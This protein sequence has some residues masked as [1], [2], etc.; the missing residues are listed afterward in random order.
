MLKKCFKSVVTGLVL[1]ALGMVLSCSDNVGLGESVDTESPSIEI[2]YPPA[3]AIIRGSFVFAGSWKD[4]KGVKTVTAIITNTATKQTYPANT[5]TVITKSKVNPENAWYVTV[6]N[7]SED[8]ADYVNNWQLPDGKYELGVYATD[9]AGHKS[10]I[11]TR[12]FEIDNTAPVTVLTSPGSTST[13]TAYGST[14]SVEGTIADEHAV[15]SLAVTIYDENGNVLDSTADEPYTETS[16]QTAGGTS[17]SLLKFSE[18]PVTD[19]QKRYSNIYGE[20]RE[21]GTKKYSCAIYVRDNARIYGEEE[22]KAYK[23]SGDATSATTGNETSVFYLNASV[24]ETLLSSVK[25]Y[26]LSVTDLMTIIN[27]TYVPSDDT[28]ARAAGNNIVKGTLTAEELK[29]VQSLLFG[30]KSVAVDTSEEHL[31]FSLDPAVNPI[32]TVSGFSLEDSPSGTKNQTV[33]FIVSPGLDGT[34]F[35]PNT[36]SVYLLNCGSYNA[37]TGFDSS[38]YNEFLA[39][40]AAY[41]EAHKDTTSFITSYADKYTDAD[42]LSSLTATFKLPEIVAD[43]YYI[44]GLSG[45]D[46]DDNELVSDGTFGFIGALS[47]TPPV[48]GFEKPANQ[49]ILGST[50]DLVF[51]GE[52][53]TTEVKLDKL[54]LTIDVTD[55]ESGASVGSFKVSNVASDAGKIVSWDTGVE[56]D[57]DAKFKYAWTFALKD[58]PEYNSY[59]AEAGDGKIY[60]YTVTAEARDSSG[61]E[62]TANRTVTVDTLPPEV[63]ITSVIPSVSGYTD[64]NHSDDSVVYV[65][66]IITI[67]GSVNEMNHRATNYTVYVGDRPVEDLTDCEISTYSNF[68][69]VIDTTKL[70][71][72]KDSSGNPIYVDDVPLTV[73]VT[74]EDR[75]N[76][77]LNA[78]EN[79]LPAGKGKGN[80]GSY[81]TTQLNG[82]KPFHIL[83]ETD[84]PVIK[85]INA[86]KDIQGQADIVTA[87]QD[88]SRMNKNIFAPGDKLQVTVSDD[89]GI[90]GVTVSY[91][92]AES[93]DS[94]LSLVSSYTASNNSLVSALPANYG[95]YE[96]LVTAVDSVEGRPAE[97][98]G[99][100]TSTI[101]F[102]VAMDDGAPTFSNMQP[103]S[104]GYYADKIAVS[105]SLID[106]S[107]EVTL[108]L[109]SD[110]SQGTSE[111]T[112]KDGVSATL[113][114]TESATGADF[115]DSIKV[116]DDSQTYAIVYEATDLYGQSK[117]YSIRYIV[118]KENPTV[119][120]GS[121]TVGD[122]VEGDW[123]NN[124][125]PMVKIAVKDN[126]GGSGIA[127]VKAYVLKPS[128][129]A[130]FD[131]S[132]TQLASTDFT[133]GEKDADDSTF[134]TYSAIVTLPQGESIVKIVVEDQAHN[135][136]IA[137]SF[138]VKVDTLKPVITEPTLASD[139]SLINAVKKASLTSGLT[140]TPTL[141]DEGSGL[142]AAWLDTTNDESKATSFAASSKVTIDPAVTSAEGWKPALNVSQSAL[143]DGNH[144]YYVWAEDGAGRK[145]VSNPV[146]FTVDTKVPSVTVNALRSGNTY[147][148][149][150]VTSITE[151]NPRQASYTIAGTWTDKAG[152]FSGSGTSRLF[153]SIDSGAN[154]TEITGIDTAAGVTLSWSKE[155]TVREGL[156]RTIWFKAEDVAGNTLANADIPAELKID[157][158]NFDFSAPDISL[159]AE[160]ASLA[161]QTK[162]NAVINGSIE[163]KLSLSQENIS[164]VIAR[165][166]TAQDSA[167]LTSAGISPVISQESAGKAYAFVLTIPAKADHTNDGNWTVTVNANDDAGRAAEQKIIAVLIDTTAPVITS[168]PVLKINNDTHTFDGISYLNTQYGM[169]YA[170]EANDGSGSG[171]QKIEYT[172]VAGDGYA[173]WDAAS[174]QPLAFDWI[175][176]GD[177]GT[178]TVKALAEKDEGLY[179]FF[180]RITD[181]VGNVSYSEPL[182]LYSD[183]SDP[184][185]KETDGI[186][187]YINLSSSK[188]FTLSGTVTDAQNNLYR[189]TSQGIKTNENDPATAEVV[190]DQAAGTW[191]ITQ[192]V[193]TSDSDT[194]SHSFTYTINASDKAGNTAQPVQKTVYIDRQAPVITIE[195]LNGEAYTAGR[196]IN[197]ANCRITGK[198]EDDISGVATM[199]GY[200]KDKDG[201]EVPGSRTSIVVGSGSGEKE[202]NVTFVISG[203]GEYTPVFDASDNAGNQSQSVSGEV[204]AADFNPPLVELKIS[205]GTLVEKDTSS[206]P[207]TITALENNKNYGDNTDGTVNADKLWSNGKTYYT[208]EAF[209]IGGSVTDAFGFDASDIVFTVG[210]DSASIGITGTDLLNANWSYSQT[211]SEGLYSYNLSVK[212]KAGNA[213]ATKTFTVQVDMTG[214]TVTIARPVSGN[215]E[216][217]NAVTLSGTLVDAG[218]GV[219]EVS[220]SITNGIVTKEGTATIDGNTWSA[221]VEGLPLGRLTLTVNAKDYLDNTA[222]PVT[223]SFYRD[224]VKPVLT[225]SAISTTGKTDSADAAKVWFDKSLI[226]FTAAAKDDET[227]L[228]NILYSVNGGSQISMTTPDANGSASASNVVLNEGENTISIVA[229]DIVG[230]TSE[231]GSFS[232]LKA[233]VDTTKPAFSDITL[234]GASNAADFISNTPVTYSGSVTEDNL[235]SLT[236]S[237][238]LNG[239]DTTLPFADP[240]VA[241]NF[242][243]TLP[244]TAGDG[245]WVFTVTVTDKAGNT[246]STTTPAVLL[247]TQAPAFINTDAAPL[248]FGGKS[249]AG[250]D[251]TATEEALVA[252]ETVQAVKHGVWLKDT[253]L[254]FIGYYTESGSGID[255]VKCKIVGSDGN[256]KN[257]LSVTPVRSKSTGDT[258]SEACRFNV[259]DVSGIANG[260]IISFYA[261]DNAKNTSAQTA[262]YKI[263]ID[264]VDPAVAPEVLVSVDD[265]TP[266]AVTDTILS[267][268]TKSLVIYAQAT[269]SAS[270]IDNT[271]ISL[272]TGGTVQYLSG[273]AS[274]AE[275]ADF[276]IAL[277]KE[278]LESFGKT[279]YLNVTVKDLAG[280]TYTST[281]ATVQIDKEAPTVTIDQPSVASTINKTITLSGS[282]KD[283][284]KFDYAVL[285]YSINDGVTW[286]KFSGN[287]KVSLTDEE[288]TQE[289]DTTSYNNTANASTLMV[290]LTG[291]DAAGNSADVTK[292]Y[293]INQDDDRPIVKI[294]NLDNIGSGSAKYVLKYATNAQLTG[295]VIDDDKSSDEDVVTVLKI[296][297]VTVDDNANSSTFEGWET[298]WTV[299][300]TDGVTTAS[301]AAYGTTTLSG[302]EW[303]FTPASANQKDGAYKLYFYVQDKRSSEFDSRVTDDDKLSENDVP[304]LRRP[305]WQ[306][307]TGDKKDT[308]NG[309]SYS[310]DGTSPEVV[311]SKVQAGKDAGEASAAELINVDSSIVLGGPK[312]RYAIFTIPARDANGVTAISMTVTGKDRSDSSKDKELS[313]S[314]ETADST[315]ENG[316]FTSSSSLSTNAV[317]KT[318]PVDFGLFAT[319]TVKLVII[320]TDGSGLAGRQTYDFKI[321]Q[322]G[323]NL[324]VKSPSKTEEKTGDITVQGSALDRGDAG[325]ESVEY[326]VPT[327]A[328]KAMT[329]DQL[330]DE[331]GWDGNLAEDTTPESWE[332]DFNGGTSEHDNP[333]FI[334]F[335][336]TTKYASVLE[337]GIYTIPLYIKAT[338]ILGNSTIERWEIKH[339]PDG[340]KPKI[341]FTYPT[342][343]DYDK[344]SAGESLSYV[345]LGGTIRVAGSAI[346]PS[347]TTT[348]DK[349][350]Y[351]IADENGGFSSTD[352]A[353]ASKAITEGGYG[354]TVV[355]VYDVLNVAEDTVFTDEELRE[356]G[357]ASNEAAKAW[358]G[359]AAYGTASWNIVLNANGELNAGED[360]EDA[361]KI[362]LRACGLNAK[363]KFGVWSGTVAIH[364]DD[365]APIISSVI[366]KYDEAITAANASTAVPS[367]SQDYAT[368]MFL[369][370]QWYLVL[371]VV[372][373][374]G[375]DKMPVLLGKTA[376]DESTY[377]KIETSVD[378][379]K[380]GVTTTKTGYIAFVPISQE[381]ESLTY[382]VTAVD[383][384]ATTHTATQSFSFKIDNT[385]PSLDNLTGNKASLTESPAPAIQNDSYVYKLAGESNDTGSGV[386]RVVFY[387]MRKAG[388]TKE[389]LT[390]GE[391]I[392]DPLIDISGSDYAPA[393]VA[394]PGSFDSV[395]DGGIDRLE[396]T[397]D[398]KTYYLYAYK[399]AGN[400]TAGT[401]TAKEKTLDA[402]VR[403]GGLIYIDG[404]YRKITAKTATTATFEPA[405]TEAKD[406][407]TAWFPIAQV[408]DTQI[409]EKTSDTAAHPFVFE[410]NKDDGDLMPESFNKIS[411][412]WY[413]DASIHSDNLPDGPISLVILAFD[414]AG[415]VNGTTINTK[416]TNN[417]P[418]L[419]KLFLATDLNSND[420]F[421]NEEFEVYNIVG[422]TGQEQAAYELDFES[423]GQEYGSGIF[424]AKNKLAVVPELVG[425]NG[426]ITLVAKKDADSKA[427]VTS[428]AG[429]SVSAIASATAADTSAMSLTKI[430]SPAYE[431][432]ADIFEAAK[433]GNNFYAYVLTNAQLTG[434]DSPTESDDGTNKPFSFTFWDSTEE[435][436]SGTDS[437]NSVLWV[438]NFTF[439][440]VDGIAPT[441]VVNPFYWKTLN[442]NSIYESDK[443]NAD[444][445]YAVSST[446]DL[447]GHIELEADW[448]TTKTYTDNEAADENEKNNQYDGDPKVSGK[449]T[450]T[451]TAYDE[452]AL[453]SL[454]FSFGKEGNAL[455]TNE[456]LTEYDTAT[457]KWSNTAAWKTANPDSVKTMAANGYEVT[458]VEDA[459]NEYGVYE[460]SVYFGQSGHKIYWTLSID[461]E[462]I[463]GIA[464]TDMVLTVL[465]TDLA[466]KTTSTDVTAPDVSADYIPASTAGS[467]TVT[468]GTTNVPSYQ[469]DIVPYVTKVSTALRS[470]LKSSIKDTYSRTA[471]GH[472]IARSTENITIEGFNLGS[473]TVKPKYGTTELSYTD[474]LVTLPASSLS[475]SGA[476]SLTVGDVETLN[477]MNN[478]NA[479]GAYANVITENSLYAEKKKYAYNRTP[480][481]TSNNLLT[482]DLVVDVWEFN[483]EAA[484]PESGELREPV[485]RINPVSG[486]VGLA[487]VSGPAHFA[488]ANGDPNNLD[489][490]SYKTWQR[491]YATYNNVSFTYDAL[492]YSHA[493]GTGLDTNPSSVH[494]GKFTY[495]YSKWGPSGTDNQNG[496]YNGNNAMRLEGIGI[497]NKT[498]TDPTSE[499]E[500]QLL[501]NG[502][503]PSDHSLS[504]TRFNSPSIATTVHGSGTSVTT[505]VYLA[506]FDSIQRQIR[507]RYNS[508]LTGS[509]GKKAA[510]DDFRDNEGIGYNTDGGTYKESYTSRFSLIAGVDYQQGEVTTKDG[511]TCLT[512]YDT[513]YKAGKYVSI[514]AIAGTASAN[515]VVVAV[516]YDG[517][518]CWY[519]YNTAPTSGK[520]NGAAGGWAGHKKI[521]SEGGE[522]CA[523]KV[524]PNNGI[525]IAAYVDGGL[526]YAYLSDYTK[527]ADYSESNDSV[528][529]DSFTVVGE[530]ITIDAGQ[531]PVKVGENTTYVVVPYISYFNGTSRLPSVAK[532]V[533]PENGVM[534]YKAQGTGTSDGNDIF[535][536]N[537][538]VSL[539]PSPK[540]LTVMYYDKI[541]IGLW[542]LNK[543]VDAAT[544]KG[545]IVNSNDSDFSGTV[546]NKTSA[547]N[548]AGKSEGHIYG[549]GTANPIL[550][551]AIDSDI[552]TCFETAQM[553]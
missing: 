209:T 319:E 278:Q 43:N 533:V 498:Y 364:V 299:S 51:G 312:K 38:K 256:T 210:S 196:K 152:T 549:N 31:R 443:I 310:V 289:I 50:A 279:N 462:K 212:D 269:D 488:M 439:D 239:A 155:I 259:E 323:P 88:S 390:N 525:H 456:T 366:R 147:T 329:D 52:V 206:S 478:N 363:K 217:E 449:I 389:T 335:D 46:L 74:S 381:S 202:W 240:A 317:W 486:K 168:Q 39:D 128:E 281:V 153:Y 62:N 441:V 404:L 453:K 314:T 484:I 16:I 182:K 201:N 536:G 476:V 186:D 20:S 18:R 493:T 552:G 29:E 429:T 116:P 192:S 346:I 518:D 96:I 230:N 195:N 28:T 378:E 184:V 158:L 374:S 3:S 70:W 177:D 130:G 454:A 491:N 403:T 143:N 526:R 89:D 336:D 175:R 344:D 131:R 295:T 432:T 214:P 162:E 435:T 393:K 546:K 166:G 119:K 274:G 138:T 451:G 529:V 384:D 40:P 211:A 477:N 213:A 203:D 139:E 247:D 21:G 174:S 287:G 8:N 551:Y 502:F 345:T 313:F 172:A 80:T 98:A 125:S 361:N 318:P 537:W 109:K 133:P 483:S 308:V 379:V 458:I 190:W 505:A 188:T 457:G 99:N 105:G 270:G 387:Y 399:V 34:Q 69:I 91:R 524:D 237:A 157:N 207:A 547:N 431:V 24:Y 170:V 383:K 55:V 93:S 218:I 407:I 309:L 297:N 77:E 331:T 49:A 301:H 242:S 126:D 327:A 9:H 142:V 428:A 6:N 234:T 290:K 548:T 394:M 370:G 469:M 511:K 517:T 522:H 111:T 95:V 296:A 351:Q 236:V 303:T 509:A 253:T 30:D 553:K 444:E 416:V 292:S 141:V 250:I 376:V 489:Y 471:L 440:L 229:K 413:W 108:R 531:V 481:Q 238:K 402:H 159:S 280:R 144:V 395:A 194:T 347:G 224:N 243:F 260:D 191:T 146:T 84:K 86:D 181:A 506:Y 446:G 225:A 438:K 65:N 503:V 245:S 85:P 368:D 60:M 304:Q 388:K 273:S 13:Y 461:T 173:S 550:G 7:Y 134:T 121:L 233:W 110:S 83:Q 452:H 302:N 515:D 79:L 367:A 132:N 10:G 325:T 355:S 535:T 320:P 377:V 426:A 241:N 513:G 538:E 263:N 283:K 371:T 357:F 275:T 251:V 169:D 149:N 5:V 465:A 380:N 72:E 205:A 338:D 436:T 123:F 136:T 165:D 12:T 520:D 32:Y 291:Y 67:T 48:I 68:K 487:F 348:V 514:D 373:E 112:F 27:G 463:T 427:P 460:D 97:N 508:N 543:T 59:K 35:R 420:K 200:L 282:A 208:K 44:I 482:D 189:V 90:S 521:F 231:A 352:A 333:S 171:I 539:V 350:F 268:T 254:T 305:Y 223:C 532:L 198:I 163:D 468:D 519:A 266:V 176:A 401:F 470:K 321:D 185:V 36:F 129:V 75:A 322:T 118:D 14:F 328:Q 330:A 160:T 179:T 332:F 78:N 316:S 294:T 415:N 421:E 221:N 349:V 82:G 459:G 545:V 372:D 412:T 244:A 369:R 300:T 480:N 23:A 64:A 500:V 353:K 56:K 497:P 228:A 386:E 204:F 544:V 178:A 22:Y 342:E 414:E 324:I 257:D 495:F 167:A 193:T 306:F 219:K 232:T 11:A 288:W 423:F 455:F 286:N 103:P 120:A 418:R 419:A 100:G 400:T 107:G 472:Y 101:S 285:E 473:T 262:W 53:T 530:R 528:I 187:K 271:S 490:S 161:K 63:S 94:P 474:G 479:K 541:N 410:D 222:T 307:K 359:I 499:E 87:T 507:F 425:G 434:K 362:T 180:T 417:A 424:T 154:W 411:D 156:N 392:L 527:S 398:S 2:A 358:W 437:Q 276:A 265:A 504:E 199:T 248:S 339:N 73:V 293:T 272:S 255:S 104:N 496:N 311:E 284:V 343:K 341:E 42:T 33:T 409:S 501:V 492:G 25:G 124:T 216:I 26:G 41:Y 37:E 475:T 340:D 315:T 220:Y 258:A 375:I 448:K 337:D 227:G 516:W 17:V 298:D 277:T 510:N 122:A 523:I 54:T 542:K 422:K 183:R 540:T 405:L 115:T 92:S 127:T 494:A 326:L 137:D 140:L 485:M 15:E 164:L 445:S 467:R 534:N 397:Q 354:Y 102:V 261:E 252:G 117:E 66:G 151:G 150:N 385:P 408:I 215:N 512:G 57:A 226:D 396:I 360:S 365:K 114:G 382:T 1:G 47:G 45:Y 235:K 246:N 71:I 61:G 19:A 466:G 148:E 450:F 81:S 4:D 197:T 145:S 76:Q 113:H 430:G 391:M 334:N 58:A 135:A 442:S 464:A 264:E 106:K 447:Q 356:Y 249:L 433:A 267:N 406:D